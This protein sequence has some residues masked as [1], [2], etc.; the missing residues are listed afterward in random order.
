MKYRILPGYS[1]RDSDETI[2]TGGD[3]IELSD[4]IATKY[5]DRVEAL[6]APAAPASDAPVA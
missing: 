1:F 2:K 4:D 3:T 5:A 6:D